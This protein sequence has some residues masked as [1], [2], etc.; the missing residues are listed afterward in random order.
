MIVA[1]LERVTA[2]SPTATAQLLELTRTDSR[3]ED[4]ASIVASAGRPGL[5]ERVGRFREQSAAARKANRS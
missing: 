4:V 2:L 5:K 3:V 1:R